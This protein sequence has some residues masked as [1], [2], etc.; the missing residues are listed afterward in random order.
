F[1]DGRRDG[2]GGFV[3]DGLAAAHGGD[4]VGEG[5]QVRGVGGDELEAVGAH[6]AL[7]SHGGVLDDVAAVV[8][9]GDAVAQPVGLVEV[10]GGEHDC[11]AVGGEVRDGVPDLASSGRVEAGGRLVQEQDLGGQDHAGGEV[12][13]TF[14]AA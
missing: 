2:G 14:H 13:A 4:D 12:Q 6:A 3:G 8:D 11:G 10:V 7:E 5:R 1:A 9:D